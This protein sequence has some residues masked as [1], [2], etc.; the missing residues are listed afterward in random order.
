M[1]KALF[2]FMFL[3]CSTAMFANGFTRWLQHCNFSLGLNAPLGL[4]VTASGNSGRIYVRDDFGFRHGFDYDM[5]DATEHIVPVAIDIRLPFYY[6]DLHTFGADI[7][8]NGISTAVMQGHFDLYYSYNISRF[9]EVSAFGGMSMAGVD[10]K[11]GEVREPFGYY[12][13]WLMADEDIELKGASLGGFNIGASV[14]V[15]P[16]SYDKLFFQAGY[17]YSSKIKISDYDVKIGSRK[18]NVDDDW[19]GDVEVGGIHHL[20]LTFGWGF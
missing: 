4:D 9:V 8:C 11:L 16:F 14:K 19:F 17:R 18:V 7:T 20:F 5:D 1:K 12:Y 13:G 10:I 3:L 15:R 2:V 6:S